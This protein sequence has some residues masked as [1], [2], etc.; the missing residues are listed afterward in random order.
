MP[1]KQRKGLF[2]GL[3][4]KAE[5]GLKSRKDKLQEEEDKATGKTKPKSAPKPKDKDIKK[6]P[7]KK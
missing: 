3:L 7:K 2:G 6:K 5:E 1:R 4:G